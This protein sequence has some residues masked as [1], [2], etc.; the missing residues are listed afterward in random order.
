MSNDKDQIE[1]NQP[2]EDGRK[3][4]PDL[5]DRSDMQPGVSTM[6]SSPTDAA[7]QQLTKTAADNFRTTDFGTGAD[8]KFDE[9]DE[10]EHE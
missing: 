9:V 3:N 4:D 1:R 10:N 2:A 8:K 7:N 6:S 5:R